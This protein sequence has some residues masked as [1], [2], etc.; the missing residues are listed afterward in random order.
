MLFMLCAHTWIHVMCDDVVEPASRGVFPLKMLE[1]CQNSWGAL[2][3]SVSAVGR[4]TA[5]VTA[6]DPVG[7]L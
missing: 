1:V 2:W 6:Q 5:T 4:C 7:W 3:I